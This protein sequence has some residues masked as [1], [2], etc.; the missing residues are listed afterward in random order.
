MAYAGS[1]LYPFEADYTGLSVL[2]RHRPG[3]V[4]LSTNADPV[5]GKPLISAA[6]QRRH[7]ELFRGV[8]SDA[9]RTWRFEALTANSSV[10]NLR[11]I[12]PAWNDPRTLLVWMRGTY[13]HNRGDWTTAVVA[14]IVPPPRS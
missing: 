3:V 14:T 6:D 9:G 11:P 12:V 1:R 4:Y 13:R 8:T 2:D 10:D 7:H 5:S